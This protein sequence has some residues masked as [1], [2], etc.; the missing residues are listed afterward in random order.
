MI[1]VARPTSVAGQWGAERKRPLAVLK[2]SSSRDSYGVQNKIESDKVKKDP[3]AKFKNAQDSNPMI[4]NYD[5]KFPH[6]GEG[7]H[8]DD[9]RDSDRRM[10]TTARAMNV[11]GN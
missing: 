11:C 5:V 8:G 4:L 1:H 2:T 9:D 7:C 10:T 3:F 6:M